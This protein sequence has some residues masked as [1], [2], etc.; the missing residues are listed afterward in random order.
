[1]VLGID[2]F[3][4]PNVEEAKTNTR[5]VIATFET[6]AASESNGDAV[7]VADEAALQAALKTALAALLS[8]GYASI[9]A[10]VA[11]TPE[12]DAALTRVRTLLRDATHRATTVGYGPRFLHSTGQLH[13]GGAPIG[14]FLQLVAGHP[15]DRAIPGKAYTFGQLIDAQAIGDARTLEDHKLPVLRINLGSDPDAGIA[16]LERALA[17]ALKEA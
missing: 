15:D 6:G 11:Q 16:S 14:W 10:Y 3:D 5:A 1:V 4:Q 7:G 8:N 13:K 12:R 9:Q 2:P 17:A